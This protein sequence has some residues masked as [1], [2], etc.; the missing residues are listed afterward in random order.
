MSRFSTGV[1]IGLAAIASVYLAATSTASS[2]TAGFDTREAAS[3][4]RNVD[5][6]ASARRTSAAREAE[7]AKCDLLEGGRKRACQS[8]SRAKERR[9]FASAFQP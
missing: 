5:F 7:R 1:I 8:E 4:S 9:G 2:F 6:S 3:H